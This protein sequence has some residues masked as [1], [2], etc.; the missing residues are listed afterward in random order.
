MQPP[1]QCLDDLRRRAAEQRQME[2]RIGYTQPIRPSLTPAASEIDTDDNRSHISAAS[3]RPQSFRTGASA[4]S[5]HSET[6]E[7]AHG[8]IDMYQNVNGIYVKKENPLQEYV[9][10][11]SGSSEHQGVEVQAKLQ[12]LSDENLL[13]Y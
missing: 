12:K 8:S 9:P 4:P 3:K 13:K 10:S 6:Y 1:Q 11:G 2:K 5:V 7:S